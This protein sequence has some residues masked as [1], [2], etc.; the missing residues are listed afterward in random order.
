MGVRRINEIGNTP[1]VVMEIDNGQ[2]DSLL[3]SG[4]IEAFYEDRLHRPT[5]ADSI[6]LI[7]GTAAFD[8]TRGEGHAVAI[9]DTGVDASHPFF[10]GRVVAEACFSSTVPIWSAVTACANGEGSQFGVGAAAPCAS[11]S[12]NHG[13]HVAGI[14]AGHNSTMSGVAPASNIVAV[15][16]FTDFYDQTICESAARTPCP[17]ALTSDIIRGLEY[18][19]S[20]AETHSVAAV[21]LSLG[22]GEFTAVCDDE[23]VKT[24]AD[25]LLSMGVATIAASGNDFYSNAINSPA[26]ISSVISVGSTTKQDEV[27]SF[28]NSALLIDLLAPGS[29]IQSAVPLGQFAVASGTSMSA[30]H[31]A[32]AFSLLRSAS[33]DASVS[34]LRDVLV[35]TGKSVTDRR[36]SIS[37]PRI[38]VYQALLE[39][40][41]A[42]IPGG[43]PGPVTYETPANNE[44]V[45][46]D[47]LGIAF[48]RS[49]NATAYD[50]SAVFSPVGGGAAIHWEDSFDPAA[51]G[52]DQ[53]SLCNLEL[54][55]LNGQ[56]LPT[57]RAVLNI[58]ARNSAGSAAASRRVFH[59]TSEKPRPAVYLSPKRQTNTR[60]PTL[61]IKADPF[62][63][64]Y[65]VRVTV[66]KRGQRRMR[67]F[68]NVVVKN[69]LFNCNR[70]VCSI[71]LYKQLR[72][73]LPADTIRFS[74]AIQPHNWFGW[75]QWRGWTSVALRRR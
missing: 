15:Q 6:P 52:C 9:V 67:P 4:L 69:S 65:R 60:R 11:A 40:D 61:R 56:K 41:D 22:S 48:H 10:A 50:V 36:N 75:G 45:I 21:N 35:R 64:R 18:V 20:V 17:L 58:V 30:P 12:C 31:V 1:Y 27:S 49:D 33:P 37:K 55:N 16:V 26:C 59:V 19:Q 29:S 74:W 57:A 66:R 68:L 73:T 34:E 7:G 3:Q 46:K 14:A 23:P 28:S 43:L 70:R 5:L 54:A 24:T 47:T 38:D 39:L 44:V 72:A 2:Y 51:L 53:E 62:V 63:T 42:D 32:G 8:R 71:N 13:T 25:S